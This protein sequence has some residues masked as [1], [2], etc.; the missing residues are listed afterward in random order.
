MAPLLR[1]Q[2][3]TLYIS[4]DLIV[5]L[6]SLHFWYARASLASSRLTDNALI[7]PG[8][9]HVVVQLVKFTHLHTLRSP[10]GQVC[11]KRNKKKFPAAVVLSLIL[12]ISH[13]L[14]S[15]FPSKYA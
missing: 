13:A 4:L 6:S 11:T 14:D 15:R 3:D 1:C 9:A 8:R 10:V 7:L 12:L 2:L 5:A